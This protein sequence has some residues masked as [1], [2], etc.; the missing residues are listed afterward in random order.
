MEPNTAI[1]LGH[2]V[3]VLGLQCGK[4]VDARWAY[5]AEGLDS[6]YRAEP[7]ECEEGCE[8]VKVT[9]Q[10]QYLVIVTLSLNPYVTFANPVC[11][12]DNF[13]IISR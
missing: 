8:P 1:K 9:T 4:R 11:S 12:F 2:P 6:F 7:V 3:E 10:R 5:L 13:F